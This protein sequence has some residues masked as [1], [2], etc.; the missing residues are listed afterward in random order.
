MRILSTI[1]VVMEKGNIIASGSATQ[2][3]EKRDNHGHHIEN[4]ITAETIV[5]LNYCPICGK[6]LKEE[7]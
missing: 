1:R 5:Q 7:A 3:L 6:N 4:T 2:E